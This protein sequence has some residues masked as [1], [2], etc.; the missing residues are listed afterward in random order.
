MKD[1]VVLRGGKWATVQFSTMATV[2]SMEKSRM[3]LYSC[4]AL[5]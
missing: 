1:A 3:T 4:P 2:T 5:Q